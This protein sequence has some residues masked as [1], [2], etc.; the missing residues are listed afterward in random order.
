MTFHRFADILAGTFLFIYALYR[1]GN[2]LQVSFNNAELIP[3]NTFDASSLALMAVCIS[4][5]LVFNT[6]RKE[7]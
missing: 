5:M 6:E 3:F 7:K 4:Y 2:R 1:V